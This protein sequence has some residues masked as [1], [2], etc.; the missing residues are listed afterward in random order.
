MDKL[1]FLGGGEMPDRFRSADIRYKRQNS[2]VA[3]YYAR[4]EVGKERKKNNKMWD[5]K[6]E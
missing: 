2:S 3:Q 6:V 1:H 5:M 4:E